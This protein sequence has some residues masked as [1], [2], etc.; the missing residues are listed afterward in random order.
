MADDIE[1][2][3]ADELT[4]EELPEGM[5]PV[6]V[7]AADAVI[8][9]VDVDIDTLADDSDPLAKPAFDEDDDTEKIEEE[10]DPEEEAYFLG[11]KYEDAL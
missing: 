5:S 7:D 3:G 10:F 9:E 2:G 11:D 4:E 1:F 6:D 8:D